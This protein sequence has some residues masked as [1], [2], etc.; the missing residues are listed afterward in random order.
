MLV[1][2]GGHRD[3]LLN[4]MTPCRGGGSYARGKYEILTPLPVAHEAPV[5]VA[6][7]QK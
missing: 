6:L 4:W 7:Y 5:Y 2:L 3:A 1:R